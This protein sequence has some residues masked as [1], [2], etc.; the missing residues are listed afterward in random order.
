MRISSFG[1]SLGRNGKAG[2][3]LTP[4]RVGKR[5]RGLC[6]LVVGGLDCLA[7]CCF[8]F[9]FFLVAALFEKKTKSERR[10]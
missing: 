7:C 5:K 3:T 8:F 1:S 4:E 9:F 10:G 6:L 2:L